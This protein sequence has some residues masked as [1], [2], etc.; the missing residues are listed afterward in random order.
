MSQVQLPSVETS[1]CVC[2]FCGEKIEGKS[3]SAVFCS[4]ACRLRW[5]R[6]RH[7]V[8]L[9]QESLRKGLA[10]LAF[11]INNA[12]TAQQAMQGMEEI[13]DSAQWYLDQW[14]AS[15]LNWLK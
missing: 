4:D 7:K 14:T 2:K 3:P 1:F 10:D 6:F 11:F 13:R 8:V 12:E 5:F 15:D 9:V